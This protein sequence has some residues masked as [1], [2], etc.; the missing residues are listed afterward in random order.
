MIGGQSDRPDPPFQPIEL[1]ATI[2]LRNSCYRHDDLLQNFYLSFQWDANGHEGTLPL[3]S[4]YHIRSQ[5]THKDRL[6][7]AVR[8]Y[9]YSETM[10][11]H[12]V[13]HH[14]HASINL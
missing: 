12:K 2:L 14:S 9:L 3:E 13:L 4:S 6:P 8:H 5:R 7:F 1:N 11:L 10:T